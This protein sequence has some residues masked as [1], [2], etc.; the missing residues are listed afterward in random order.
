VYEEVEQVTPGAK[1]KQINTLFHNEGNGKFDN[2]GNIDIVVANNGDPPL[3]HNT[4]GAGNHF[5]LVETKSNRDGLGARVR[6]FSGTLS[7]IR[8]VAAGCSYLSHRDIRTHFGLGT[9]TRAEPIEVIRPS[10]QK[11]TFQGA[12]ADKF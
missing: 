10:G 3:L 11:Q 5:K 1:Y 6:V 12:A 7:Q 4:G 8:E 9:F 2:D